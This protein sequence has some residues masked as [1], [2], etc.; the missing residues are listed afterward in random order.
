VWVPSGA[1]YAEFGLYN[2]EYRTV[3]DP[4]D[5]L[6]FF[7]LSTSPNVSWVEFDDLKLGDDSQPLE[8][9]PYDSRRWADVTA[10]FQPQRVPSQSREYAVN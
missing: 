8:I 10:R 3:V 5:R 2:T 7:E 9:N 4:T 6:Y 1:L